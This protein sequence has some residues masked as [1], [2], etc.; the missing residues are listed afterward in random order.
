MP[1]TEQPSRTVVVTGAGSGI[2]RAIAEAFAAENDTVY[3]C[4]I[5]AERTAEVAAALGAPER[6]GTVDVSDEDQIGA[7]LRAAHEQTGR[8]DVLVNAA[9][10]FD[11]YAGVT[12]TSAG[13]WRKILDVNLTGCFLGA[14]AA[15]ELMIPQGSG[16]IIS[17]GSIATFRGGA[18]GIAYSAAKAGMHGMTRRLALDVGRHGDHREHDLPWRD[19]ERDQGELGG[20]ARRPLAGAAPR[21]R[22]HPGAD[23]L[24]DPRR[25][26][27]PAQRSG[28]RRRV[29]RLRRRR[30]RQRHG[31]VR[32]WW[33]GGGM[34]SRKV[35][36]AM[37]VVPY[38]FYEDTEAAAAWLADAFGFTEMLR[39]TSRDGIVTHVEMTCAGE[40]IML[41]Q[42]D[43]SDGQLL[44]YTSVRGRR[45]S[46]F[47][48]ILTPTSS[49]ISSGRSAP[50]RR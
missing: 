18:D 8:L 15:A 26:E 4:D 30:V 3:V 46:S 45:H 23:G 42:L 35:A 6:G 36:G 39:H 27:G 13:L 28:G 32:R 44:G 9:G 49:R 24:P 7:F 5:S 25:A 16:R 37:A 19:P 1:G 14:K 29:P 20:G 43:R 40:S 33:L 21:H 10:I 48:F 12:E 50:E 34:T 11:G 2:G 31:G 17:I 22:R 41:G 47:V 38:L